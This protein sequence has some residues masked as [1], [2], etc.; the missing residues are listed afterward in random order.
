MKVLSNLE[1]AGRKQRKNPS[2]KCRNAKKFVL[3]KRNNSMKPQDVTKVDHSSTGETSLR[4]GPHAAK[5]C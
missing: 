5:P 4:F 3:P 2:R 1:S